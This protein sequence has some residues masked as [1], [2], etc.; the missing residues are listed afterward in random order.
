[1]CWMDSDW[2]SYPPQSLREYR[3][4]LISATQAYRIGEYAVDRRKPEASL[5]RA[6]AIGLGQTIG[7]VEYVPKQ[8]NLVVGNSSVDSDVLADFSE[9]AFVQN[10]VGFSRSIF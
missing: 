6:E 7:E 3:T 9:S 4:D 2:T 5:K 1:M 10:A 8:L